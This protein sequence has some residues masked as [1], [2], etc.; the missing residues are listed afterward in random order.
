MS[1]PGLEGNRLLP[2]VLMRA[3]ARVCDGIAALF[4]RG[5]FTPNA[6]TV[7]SFLAGAACGALIAWERPFAAWVALCVSGILDAVDGR[8]AIQSGR[9]TRFGAVLDSTLDRYSEFCIFAGLAYHFRGRWTEGLVW[10]AFLGAMMVSYTR[11]RAEA[12]GVESRFG[13]M[14]RPERV[15]LLG[16]GVFLG[17]V[18]KIFDAAMAVVLGAIALLSHIT[19]GQRLLAV[20]R[21]EP[22]PPG[23]G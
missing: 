17:A 14:Q 22:K 4:V 10:V 18:F 13:L 21:A 2:A 5:R 3:S 16:S 1:E 12:T 15:V 7:L 6:V 8:V 11:A 20:R 23:K 9:K 19:A